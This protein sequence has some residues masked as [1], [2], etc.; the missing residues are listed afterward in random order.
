MK[1][2]LVGPNSALESGSGNT[3]MLAE[4]AAPPP[5][6]REDHVRSVGVHLD[7]ALLLDK[8][9]AAGARSASSLFENEEADQ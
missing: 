8:E 1:L 2:L 4:V 9:V 5:P 6:P 3:L 7:P